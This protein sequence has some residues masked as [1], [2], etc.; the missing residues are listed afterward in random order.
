MHVGGEM[1]LTGNLSRWLVSILALYYG[2]FFLFVTGGSYYSDR[3]FNIQWVLPNFL[4]NLSF[5]A[6][7]MLFLW[8]PYLLFKRHRW[9]KTLAALA[10]VGALIWLLDQFLSTEPSDWHGALWFIPAIVGL[11]LLFVPSKMSSAQPSEK[12]A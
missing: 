2:V 3:I 8:I 9:A 1:K 10:F 6:A 5:L 12:L 11:G 4:Q 7:G